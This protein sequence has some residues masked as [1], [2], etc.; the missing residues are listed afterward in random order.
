MPLYRPEEK[1]RRLTGGPDSISGKDPLIQFQVETD[2]K[3]VPQF[4]GWSPQVAAGADDLLQHGVFLGRRG[5]TDHFFPLGHFDA[6]GIPDF[7]PCLPGVDT[8]LSRLQALD[9]NDISLPQKLQSFIAGRSI[10]AQI[11]PVNFHHHLL[12]QQRDCDCITIPQ[13]ADK[14]RLRT[15]TGSVHNNASSL[16]RSIGEK[17]H[18]VSW[19][20]PGK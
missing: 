5:K 8:I 18:Q 17:K 15:P 7:L 9:N 2:D 6:G 1:R 19:L 4:Q 16:C 11:G 3:A 12:K 10:F 14:L 20:R 13:F